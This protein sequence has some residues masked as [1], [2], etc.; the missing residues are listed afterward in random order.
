MTLSLVLFSML[1]V[2]G[3]SFVPET[4]ASAP[5]AAPVTAPR[6]APLTARATVRDTGGK[7]L[8]TLTLTEGPQGVLVQ[9]TL[10][11]PRTQKKPGAPTGHHAFH[12]HEVGRCDPPF[13]SAGGHFNPDKKLHGFHTPGGAHA[14]DLP[15]LVRPASGELAFETF[16]SGVTLSPG[17][18][19]L[20]DADGSAVVLHAQGDDYASQPAG[21]AGDRMAC[22]VVHVGP[23]R[24]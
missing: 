17:P 18:R 6:M 2:D 5:A 24:L 4:P 23:A 15:N 8:G 1:A 13:A 3:G 22:G 12:F 16:A 9:G 11:L 10:R 19:S 14:G 21:S 7:A 20:L